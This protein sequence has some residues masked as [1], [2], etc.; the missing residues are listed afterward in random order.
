M[1]REARSSAQFLLPCFQAVLMN[2]L[3]IN[4]QK[5][6]DFTSLNFCFKQWAE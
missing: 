1:G 5:M 2:V 6:D 4:L 3:C